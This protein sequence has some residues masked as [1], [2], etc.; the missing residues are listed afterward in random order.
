MEMFT[1]DKFVTNLINCLPL[2]MVG[3]SLVNMRPLLICLVIYTQFRY[4]MTF[5]AVP[6]GLLIFLLLFKC[7]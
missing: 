1:K 4:N 5:F 6:Y 2:Q 3:L 7:S